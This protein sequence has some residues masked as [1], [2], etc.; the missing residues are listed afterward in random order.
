MNSGRSEIAI[1]GGGCFWCTEAAFDEL[2][3]VR[4]VQSGYA[5]GAL[6]NP[7]YEQ[8]CTGRTGHAEVVRVEF[9]PEVISYADLLDVFFTVHD[10][11]TLNRQGADVGTQYRSVIFYLDERQK[12]IAE[13]KIRDIEAGGL[14]SGPIVTEVSPA[15]EFYPAEAAHAEYYRRNPE[16]GYC[17]VVISPKLARMRQRHA[18]LL[19]RGEANASGRSAVRAYQSEPK[20]PVDQGGINE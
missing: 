14:W 12:K 4:H 6:P 1:L 17:Q 8:I 5:G 7:S 11:T 13:A 15:P 2:H 16:A 18:N 20:N 19:R 9:D 10:P 3:G